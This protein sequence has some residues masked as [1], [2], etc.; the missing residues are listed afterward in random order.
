MSVPTVSLDN[1]LVHRAVARVALTLVRL[2]LV[3]DIGAQMDPTLLRLTH[4]RLSSVS[5]FP[6]LLITHTGANSRK[7]WTT[8]LVYFT[9]RGRVI[10]IATNVGAARN[11]SWYHNVK[12]TRSSK[13]TGGDKWAL[14]RCG[15]CRPRPRLAGIPPMDHS[16]ET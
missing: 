7:V 16:A 1:S 12:P 13:C 6:A 3:R 4:G 9:D 11:P 10:L 5:T 15:R 14:T 8:A 2:R